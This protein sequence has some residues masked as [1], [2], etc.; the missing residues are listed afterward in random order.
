MASGIPHS[1]TF[2]GLTQKVIAY[3]EGFE[4]VIAAAKLRPLTDADWAPLDALVDAAK[5]ERVGV[6]L[7]PQ[8]QTIG[9]DAY[10]AI[11]TRYGAQTQWDGTLRRITEGDHVVI[12]E[13]EERNT[14]AGKMDV[15]NTVTVFAFDGAGKIVH[16]D[17]YVAHL[18][19]RA[20]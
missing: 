17:V 14:T 4:A 13:L 8:V 7:G 19:T 12:Q 3:G 15:S 2:G 16:L 10:K 20:G 18:E 6:F 1:S 9:W 11:I 5:W